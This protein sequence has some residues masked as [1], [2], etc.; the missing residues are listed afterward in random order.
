MSRHFWWCLPWSSDPFLPLEGDWWWQTSGVPSARWWGHEERISQKRVACSNPLSKWLGTY[1]KICQPLQKFHALL[2]AYLHELIIACVSQKHHFGMLTVARIVVDWNSAFL[3]HSN[4]RARLTHSSPK[5]VFNISKVSAPF[6]P[7]LKA[8]RDP[9]T[10][11]LL[12]RHFE[13]DPKCDETQVHVL[14]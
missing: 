5:A 6:F 12:F 11:F 8:K 3:N 14:V 1:R 13:R 9:H 7:S 4:V 2:I 10:L